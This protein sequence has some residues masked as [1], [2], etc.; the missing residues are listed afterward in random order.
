MPHLSNI[1]D[2]DVT[3]EMA[4]HSQSRG[5][6]SNLNNFENPIYGNEFDDSKEKTP[7]P[8]VNGRPATNTSTVPSTTLYSEVTLPDSKSV[9]ESAPEREHK[10]VNTIYGEDIVGNVYS[11]ASHAK[12]SS[13]LLAPATGPAKPQYEVLD[14]PQYDTAEA[15]DYEVAAKA[16]TSLYANTKTGLGNQALEEPEYDQAKPGYEVL[17]AP[18]TH[19]HKN[20]AGNAYSQ[21]SHA[22]QSPP[23]SVETAAVMSSNLEYAA[24]ETPEYDTAHPP[25][26]PPEVQEYDITHQPSQEPNSNCPPHFEYDTAYPPQQDYD[27]AHP[28][29][30][31]TYHMV[32]PPRE[33][34]D[35]TH[36]PQGKA[37]VSLPPEQT[38]ETAYPPH[39]DNDLVAVKPVIPAD[40]YEQAGPDYSEIGH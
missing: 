34:Y 6:K 3:Y 7:D 35:T 25:S 38:Y 28:P 32:Y 26:Q 36:V 5:K 18:A 24:L 17:E 15:L 31:D 9:P 8:T 13:R 21:T 39:Q 29:P 12:P 40:R 23:L 30:Q 20:L 11:Q 37:A 1:I 22:K 2:I 14:G 16:K 10:F 19:G 4:E 27:R 33:E